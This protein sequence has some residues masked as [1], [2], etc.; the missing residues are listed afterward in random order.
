MMRDN[1]VAQG[2]EFGVAHVVLGVTGAP[3]A[4]DEVRYP[5]HLT[6]RAALWAVWPPI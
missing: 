5:V 1:A 6:A 2:D 3:R 4:D